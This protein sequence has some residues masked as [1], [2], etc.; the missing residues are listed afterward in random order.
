M[1]LHVTRSPEGAAL[2]MRYE[3]DHEGCG[4]SPTDEEIIAGGGMLKLGWK[5]TFCLDERR[6][7]HYCPDHVSDV[8]EN[9]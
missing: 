8:E 5:I 7:K 9:S 6:N 1:T 3:C 4:A 2:K